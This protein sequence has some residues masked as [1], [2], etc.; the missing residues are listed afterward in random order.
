MRTIALPTISNIFMTFAWPA[1][2][3]GRIRKFRQE[4][5]AQG[6]T[7]RTGSTVEERP[8]KP[9]LFHRGVGGTCSERKPHFWQRRHEVGYL[10]PYDSMNP[11]GA[12]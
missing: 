12:G 9:P 10:I 7:I 4:H 2:V 6:S 11:T 3:R 8:L 5:V 1:S